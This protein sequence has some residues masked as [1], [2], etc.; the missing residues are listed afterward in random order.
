MKNWILLSFLI[1]CCFGCS[2]KVTTIEA[3]QNKL[4]ADYPLVHIVLF[5]VKEGMSDALIKELERM[6][7]IESVHH[8]KVGKFEDLNDK[9]A[10]AEYDLIM[11][12]QFLDE[13]SYRQYQN[14]PLHLSLKKVAS[15]MLEKAPTSYDYTIQNN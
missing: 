1:T 3:P 15:Q 2:P 5:D 10:M 12:M 9:R 11:Q 14:H 4:P 6:D 8:L 7:Q 13:A